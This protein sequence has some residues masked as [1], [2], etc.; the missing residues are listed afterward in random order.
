MST[1]TRSPVET[2]IDS[3]Q[4]APLLGWMGAHNPIY[5]AAGRILPPSPL[6]LPVSA[7]SSEWVRE[8]ERWEDPVL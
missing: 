3:T 8:P 7:Q 6:G 1:S 2:P 4:R 5:L